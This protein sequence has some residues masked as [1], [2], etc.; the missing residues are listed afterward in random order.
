[1]QVRNLTFG[2]DHSP[3]IS[4]ASINIQHG[5]TLAV[6]GSNGSGKTTLLR[7]LAGLR[8][9]DSGTVKQDGVIGFAPEDPRAALFAKSVE[10]EVAFFPRNQGLDPKQAAEQSMRTMDVY[11]L[12]E[13]NPLSL[14]FGEQRRVS[15]AAVLSG[16]PAV[17][18]LDEPTAGLG[19]FNERE[20]GALFSELG[21]TV[22]FS[23]HSSGFAYEFADRVAVLDEG[24]FR[25]VGSA[26]KILSRVDLLENAGIRPPGIVSWA[27]NRGLEHPP[28]TLEEAVD[29][30]RGVR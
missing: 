6:M 14:S 4:G 12:R 19:A 26:K 23:T 2:Y 22:V 15:I 18:A 27:I 7:L 30:V 28:T 8:E 5:E 1:M 10:E 16:N 17:M 3:V 11:E 13:R 29:E 24:R 20:L 21:T 9:P 25:Q